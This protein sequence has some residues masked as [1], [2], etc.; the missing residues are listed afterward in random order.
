MEEFNSDTRGD[1]MKLQVA[2]DRVPFDKAENLV[3]VIDGLADVIEIGTSLIKDYGLFKLKEL[4]SKKKTSKF[5]V[6]NIF[7]RHNHIDW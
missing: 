4:S 6:F 5:D 2:I 3:K 7:I 1:K